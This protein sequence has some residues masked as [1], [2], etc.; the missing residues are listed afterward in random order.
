MN[1]PILRKVSC[2]SEPTPTF[3]APAPAAFTAYSGKQERIRLLRA[4]HGAATGL[5]TNSELAAPVQVPARTPAITTTY[6]SCPNLFPQ[7]YPLNTHTSLNSQWIW[8]IICSISVLP[9]WE[10]QHSPAFWEVLGASARTKINAI[11]NDLNILL[12]KNGSWGWYKQLSILNTAFLWRDNYVERS[13]SQ[14]VLW[15]WYTR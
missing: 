11:N 1:I 6:L 9:V 5:E 2:V 4:A 14:S 3:V 12:T 8:A 10:R 13:V 15:T 7:L